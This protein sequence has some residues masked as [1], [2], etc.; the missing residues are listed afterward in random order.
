MCVCVC[1]CVCL[2]VSVCLCVDSVNMKATLN[3]GG[4]LN[5]TIIILKSG[6]ITLTGQ[7]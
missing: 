7:G 2:F 3:V 4:I 1:V 6:S 5:M